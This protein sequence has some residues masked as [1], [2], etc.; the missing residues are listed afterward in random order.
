MIWR[1]ILRNNGDTAA[2]DVELD[3]VELGFLA[4]GPKRAF[5]TGITELMV[6]GVV[7]FDGSKRLR[8]TS[9]GGSPV[10]AF[11]RIVQDGATYRDA[12]RGAEV[13]VSR[14]RDRLAMQ[15]LALDVRMAMRA[16]WLPL[17]VFVP[18]FPLAFLKIQSGLSRDR[19]VGF[20]V[21]AV[22]VGVLV[23]LWSVRQRPWRTRAGD[24]AIK[25]MRSI[26]GRLTRAPQ[27]AELALAVALAGPAILMGTPY[28]TY[29]RITG[30][31]SSGSD[32]GCGSSDGGDGGG[33]DGGGGC[34]GGSS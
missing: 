18:V 5:D 1:Q 4:G 33:G 14:I 25:E 20:L 11:Q 13:V 12:R 9:K 17:L 26:T 2:H 16:V 22:A 32:S 30:T 34:G 28:A 7:S 27:E 24:A 31:G 15:G 10:N 6:A 19:P 21:T 29:A 8:V 23:L 3:P